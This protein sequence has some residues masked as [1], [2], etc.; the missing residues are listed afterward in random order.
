MN[1]SDVIYERPL[2]F[3]I[4]LSKDIVKRRSIETDILTLHVDKVDVDALTVNTQVL[5]QDREQG[6]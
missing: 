2:N 4:A 1:L 3:G 6:S 5:L